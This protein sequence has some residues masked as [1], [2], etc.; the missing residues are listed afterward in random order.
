MKREPTFPVLARFTK[1]QFEQIRKLANAEKRSMG[2]QVVV[3][4]QS[5]LNGGTSEAK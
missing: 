5:R 1:E 2:N 4:V 3:L